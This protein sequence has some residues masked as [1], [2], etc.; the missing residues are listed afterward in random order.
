MES[1]GVQP[2]GDLFLRENL[3]DLSKWALP[4]PPRSEAVVQQAAA[5]LFQILFEQYFQSVV[6][7]FNKI[8]F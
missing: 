4:S 8:C 3:W 7:F 6:S 1:S 2:S 5:K